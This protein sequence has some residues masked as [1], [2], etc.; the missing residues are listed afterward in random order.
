MLCHMLEIERNKMQSV[1][2]SRNCTML[3]LKANNLD[4]LVN[5][6]LKYI[7][8]PLNKARM[9]LISSKCFRKTCSNPTLANAWV[10]SLF[11]WISLAYANNC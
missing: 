11:F 10:Y 9:F 7:I 1:L 3:V 4:L 8:L 6:V 5:K 2:V